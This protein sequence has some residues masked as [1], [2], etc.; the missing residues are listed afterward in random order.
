MKKINLIMLCIFTV[1]AS[2]GQDALNFSKMDSVNSKKILSARIGNANID[3]LSTAPKV[4][5]G[6]GSTLTNS[7][8]LFI[9]DGYKFI[10]YSNDKDNPLANLKPEQILNVN[11]LKDQEATSKY[12]EQAK[13]GVILITTKNANKWSWRRKLRRLEKE[14][15][16]VK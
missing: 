7:K 10:R 2:R 9:I 11:V 15:L 13:N 8:I 12:G 1:V 16:Q 6:S 4:R 3:T 14:E 5:M